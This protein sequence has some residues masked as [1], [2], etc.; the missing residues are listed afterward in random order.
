MG[1]KLSWK[2]KLFWEGGKKKKREF[3]SYA[4]SMKKLRGAD[5][6]ALHVQIT[7][8]LISLSN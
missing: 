5:F 7:E 2:L 8:M 6:F 4:T 3:N 1:H